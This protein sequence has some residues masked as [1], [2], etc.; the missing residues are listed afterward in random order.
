MTAYPEWLPGTN[1]LYGYYSFKYGGSLQI[2]ANPVT[3]CD[4]GHAEKTLAE[5]VGVINA[6]PLPGGWLCAVSD[7]SLGRLRLYGGAETLTATDRLLAAMGYDMECGEVQ[8]ASTSHVARCVSPLAIPVQDLSFE[9]VEAARDRPFKFD[10]FRRGHGD[11]Y[12]RADIY[13]FTAI[14]DAPAVKALRV[15]YCMGGRLMV[16]P[17]TLS[18]HIA[19]TVQAWAPGDTGYFD[20]QLLGI[21]SG[22][23]LDPTTRQF[24]RLSFLLAVAVA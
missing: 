18:Q 19:G 9:K 2:G 3:D 21:E 5:I 22:A 16:S 14:L 11:P 20:G 1:W 13:R 10:S 6:I 17:Y 12:G 15:G 23:W 7:A 8:A 24:Y 4:V